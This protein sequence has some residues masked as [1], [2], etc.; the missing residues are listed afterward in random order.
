AERAGQGARRAATE[1][2]RLGDVADLTR[3]DLAAMAGAA[4]QDI[5]TPHVRGARSLVGAHTQVQAAAKLT[6]HEMLNMSRQIA[7]VGVTAAMGMNPLMILVQ[8]GP[9]IG[10]TLAMASARGVTTASAFKQV[11]AAGWAMVAPIAPLVAGGAALAAVI[12]GAAALAARKLNQENK[13]LVGSLGLTERQLKRLKDQ[14]VDTSVTIGDVFKGTFNYLAGA[15]GPLLAPV[16]KFFNELLDGITRGVVGAVKIYVG[17]WT[18]GFEAIKTVWTSLP[19]AIGDAAISAVN[20]VIRAVESMINGVI[21]KY[22]Q[23]L[24]AIR[25]LLM[26]T[27]QGAMGNLL[28]PMTA[29]DVAE[30]A[31]PYAGAARGALDAGVE[32]FK[33]GEAAGRAAVDGVLGGWS[34]AILDASKKR[35]L[36]EA[37]DADK[38][39]TSGGRAAPRDRTDERFAQIDQLIAQ[40]LQDELQTRL[41]LARDVT[42]RASLQKQ[43]LAAEA[44]ERQA[45]LRGLAAAI[46]DDKG[47]TDARKAELKER[48]LLVELI[49]ELAD[50]ARLQA[51]EDERSAELRRQS[52]EL[53]ITQ[54][55]GQIDLLALQADLTR[56]AYARN[57]IEAKILAAQHEIERIKL[58]E[59]I[60]SEVSTA[61]EKA[62]A[63]SRL[64]VLGLIQERERQQL[65]QQT[66]L[67]DAIGEATDAARG[68]RRA[69]GRRDFAGLLDNLAVAIETT[70]A[71]FRTQGMMG[72]TLT[73]GSAVAGLIGGKTGRAIGGGL[74]LAG[75]GMGLGSMLTAGSLPAVGALT[76]IL[77]VGGA[78]AIGGAMASVGALLGPIGL[79][80]GALY[81][82]AKLLNLGGK[83][84]NAGAGYDLIT[85]QVSGNKRTQETEE[86][87]RTA[88]EAI[89]QAT[90]MLR[91]SGV[92]PGSTVNGLVIG[93]RDPSQIYMSDGRTVT[94]A[95]GS[96]AE[97]VDA[98]MR[99]ML[100]GATYQT[101]AQKALVESLVAAGKG[102]EDITAALESYAQAQALMG[103]IDDAI[104]QLTD[105][106]A[107]ALEELK[108]AQE[109]QRDALKAAADAGYIS[110]E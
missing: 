34:N 17:A 85:G 42:E 97:A 55:E 99:A 72:G 69:W 25:S 9:Q 14:G 22:N 89:L 56:S 100:Q 53:A 46:A 21:A 78:G 50:G 8:Q 32:A 5:A 43:I 27:G 15:I 47:L 4:S 88:A 74:G 36:D 48:L 109:A 71:A 13:D 107:W 70:T 108:R 83:P 84:T 67:V 12:G 63:Q 52:N 37:G 35:I 66:R 51:I 49:Q 94:S 82:A 57:V 28:R 6:G 38:A 10:E 61:H 87:A 44:S 18:G 41:S 75:M 95:V 106:K 7:D 110:A 58:E 19:A 98:A 90:Q 64:N 59:V 103:S 79:A 86:A 30:V 62:V 76:G 102:F 1:V 92:T 77:G 60:A 54:R 45:K 20:L 80:A 101:D 26:A 29:V 65:A 24:P 16:G 68:L 96:A 11:A 33:R 2:E 104:L 40:A 105:P 91:G 31:N 39:R 23:L 93:T 3:M 73:A 81:A